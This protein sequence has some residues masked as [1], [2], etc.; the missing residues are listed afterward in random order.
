M[1]NIYTHCDITTRTYI[2][3]KG[4]TKNVNFYKYTVSSIL[5]NDVH[6]KGC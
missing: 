1:V 4:H 3:Y 6:Y 5:E 2:Q